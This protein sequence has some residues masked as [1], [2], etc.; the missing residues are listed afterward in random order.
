MLRD[1]SENKL[2]DT[3]VISKE[4]GHV[5][6]AGEVIERLPDKYPSITIVTGGNDCDSS[7][8]TT[9]E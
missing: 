4:G 9:A 8:E 3:N 6:D 1:I 5:K 2:E 7:A